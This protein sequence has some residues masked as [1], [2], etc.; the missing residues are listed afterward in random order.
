MADNVTS[1]AEGA[2]GN[3]TG[4]WLSSATGWIQGGIG[5]VVGM[6]KGL[7]DKVLPPETRAN[8]MSKL[9]QFMTQSPHLASFLLSQVALSGFPLLL[10]VIMTIT[11]AIL[12]LVVGLLVGLIGA[13]LFILGAIG[14]GLAFLLPTLFFTTA[15]GVAIWLFGMGA[16]YIIK[17]FNDKEVPGIHK[18]MG[19]ELKNSTG[20]SADSLMGG[21]GDAGK[22]G[23]DGASADDETTEKPKERKKKTHKEHRSHDKHKSEE[24]DGQGAL[25]L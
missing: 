21:G 1:K 22:A 19:E 18:P 15:T 16:Y 11:V 12:A 10:F 5:K 7:L 23:E 4:G 17:W 6:G 9:S 8:I 13:V 20:L 25:P 3:A 14:F 2:T 24:A